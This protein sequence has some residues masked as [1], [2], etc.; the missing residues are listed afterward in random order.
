MFNRVVK[1]SGLILILALSTAAQKSQPTVQKAPAPGFVSVIHAIETEKLIEQLKAQRKSRVGVP[2]SAPETI[3]NVTTGLVVDQSNH[4][5][6]RL[7]YID[8]N[9]KDQ[10]LSVVTPAGDIFAARL[11]GID[12]PTG[13]A[14]LSVESLKVEMP[15]FAAPDLL[16]S[17][18]IVEIQSADYV[19]QPVQE[20]IRISPSIKFS[21]GKIS[22]DS[23]YSKARGAL[24]L[25]SEELL[26]GN[27]GSIVTTFD[28]QIVGMAQYAGSGRAFL[29]P[30][31]VIRNTIAKRVLEKA[32]NVAAGWLGLMGESVARMPDTEWGSLGLE[33]KAGVVVREVS[34]NSP[35][36]TSGILPSDVIIAIDEMIVTG[37]AD[38]RA[39][40]LS[41]PA[42]QKVRFK[43]IRAR[44]VLEIETEL[45]A[46]PFDSSTNMFE[47]IMRT[48]STPQSSPREDL[49]R[50]LKE[51]QARYN[52]YRNR[53][54]LS[55]R[56]REQAMTE[57]S[58]EMRFLME[59]LRAIDA[60]NTTVASGLPSP[61][62]PIGITTRDLSIQ[63]AS[64]FGTKGGVL[65][66]SVEKGSAAESAGIK[67]GDVITNVAG[68]VIK[69]T[70]QLKAILAS[71]R[72]M[73]P[74]KVVREK[75][76][77]IIEVNSK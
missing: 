24:T 25:R 71:Q 55:P 27:D 6:T 64:T 77:I 73:T 19:P 22:P 2:G 60:A 45:G 9:D 59:R 49:E 74:L 75:R 13:F 16:A 76:E 26:A 14:V 31:D 68:R 40:L 65:V 51:L 42:G 63:L 39:R 15:R 1:A 33:N 44:Q 11:V 30:V 43:T 36:A 12:F 58:I 54:D 18:T 48:W 61:G 35:A 32:D 5:V 52:K 72:G 37:E 17:G 41:L 50:R 62:L 53:K 34:P 57:L 28:N 67:V 4:V 29:F 8:L 66:D 38:L 7:A 70:S 21:R 69:T 3:F 47:E 20:A 10:R 23:I 46:R 56:E